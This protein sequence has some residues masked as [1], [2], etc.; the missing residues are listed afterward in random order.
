MDISAITA[1]VPVIPVLTIERPADAVPLARALVK[2]GLPV[3]EITLRTRTA[4]EA[5]GAIAKEVPDAVV[6]AGTVLE[7]AQ[8]EQILRLGAKFAVSPGCT[9]DLVTATKAAGLPF[10]PGVQTVSEAMVLA[11]Q[12][13][14]VLKFFPA[15][16]AGGLAWLKAV[17]APLA[18]LSFCP[19]GGIGADTAP[20]YL[21]LPNVA[22]IGG[23]WVAPSAAVDARDWSQIER[24]AAAAASYKRS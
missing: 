16:A 22:C 17:G 13:Y 3:L 14:R 1:L 6:G 7:A 12:G 11:G 4:M 24:L 20:A 21:S 23:S 2:G 5:L 10:L 9:P 19:T 15:D 18:G 8:V